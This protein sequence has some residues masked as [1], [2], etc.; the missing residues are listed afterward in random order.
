M[1]KQ[2]RK[3]KIKKPDLFYSIP[4]IRIVI[5][6]FAALIFITFGLTICFHY[7]GNIL[8]HTMG[9]LYHSILD[10]LV[11]GIIIF[12]IN[13]IYERRREIEKWQQEIYD[14]RYQRNEEAKINIFRIIKCLSRAGAK[15][16]DLSYCSLNNME[17][18]L[19]EIGEKA[20]SLKG[21]KLLHTSLSHTKLSWINFEE[22]EF[23]YANLE[24]ANLFRANLKAAV[25]CN[26][27]LKKTHLGGA[28]LV[29][30]NLSVAN[31]AE[32]NLVGANLTDAKLRSGDA[33]HR[34]YLKS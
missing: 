18:T 28:M 20:I 22:A 5:I 12:I 29:G 7:K 10:V 21:A 6:L 32:A 13:R 25:L 17:F 23:Y 15:K 8:E 9:A 11:F 1:F 26:A 31:L 2:L 33:R 24:E 16:I 19:M 34:I 4:E 3:I 14:L 30:A 27:N